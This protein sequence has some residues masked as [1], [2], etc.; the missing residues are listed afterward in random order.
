MPIRALFHQNEKTTR[1]G[2]LSPWLGIVG[3]LV[4]VN[5]GKAEVSRI[6]ASAVVFEH[7]D[8]AHVASLGDDI[9]AAIHD[10]SAIRQIFKVGIPFGLPVAV[11]M[12]AIVHG[13]GH[14]SALIASLI[15]QD[16]KAAGGLGGGHCH[17]LLLCGAR[18]PGL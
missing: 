14:G 15:V 8:V 11:A 2:G 18:L 6:E 4:G 16:V 3:G 9:I 17:L 12:V 10:E 5:D 1:L 13:V 7:G